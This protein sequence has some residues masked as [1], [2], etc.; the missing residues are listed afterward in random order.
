LFSIQNALY[1][2]ALS[3]KEDYDARARDL[4]SPDRGVRYKALGEL[5]QALNKST[6]DGSTFDL[7]DKY[8]LF[9][10]VVETGDLG[11]IYGVAYLLSRLPEDDRLV[12]YAVGVVNAE[13][14]KPDAGEVTP[15]LMASLTYLAKQRP[16]VFEGYFNGKKYESLDDT[17]KQAFATNPVV[18]SLRDEYYKGLI[19]AYLQW[20][21]QSG[22]ADQGNPYRL[23]ML[24][25]GARLTWIIASM[26]ADPDAALPLPLIWIMGEIGETGGETVAFDLLLREYLARPTMRTAVSLGSCLGSLSMKRL[27]EAPFT[28]DTTRELLQYI[29]GEKWESV[30]TLDLAQLKSHLSQNLD[31]IR[32]DCKRRSV[33]ELG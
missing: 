28:P 30:E 21:P 24:Q 29:Y 25:V 13:R 11:H 19:S 17:L 15:L 32:A 27:F 4:T 16:D 2:Q 7:S 14:A 18:M 23:K 8:E 31:T 9:Q 5:T 20:K 33:P 3:R 10:K 6:S 26:Y 22:Q 1:A 12:E